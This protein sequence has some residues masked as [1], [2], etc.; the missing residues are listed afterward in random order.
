VNLLAEKRTAKVAVVPQS[1]NQEPRRP[2]LVRITA[3]LTVSGVA[4]QVCMLHENLAPNFETRLII[5]SLAE[6][7]SDMS[8]LLSSEQNV[9]RLPQMSREVSARTD[10]LA[11]WKILKFLRRERPEIVH[12]HTAKAGALGRS[13]AWLAG[14]PII[15]HTYHGHVF[16]SYFGALKNW[17]F[18]TIERILGRLSTRVI[19]VSES[20]Q[21]DLCSKYRVAPRE[22]FVVIENGFKLE[23]FSSL[24]RE[25]ARR[26][27]GLSP[28]D[29]VVVWAGRMVPV[30]DTQ[31]LAQ[32]I[33]RAA[34]K[35][36]KICFLILGDGTQRQEFESLIR[37][38][39]NVRLFGWQHNMAPI[40]SAADLALL[41]SRNEG[42][43]TVLIEALAAGRPFVSTNVGG[44]RD[45]AVGDLQELPGNM[46][47]RVANGYLASRTPESLL[48][49]IE[50]MANN[51]RIAKEMGSVGQSFALQHFCEGRLL[52]QM[53]KLY[54]T[55]LMERPGNGYAAVKKS[56][57]SVSQN[58]DIA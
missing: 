40:W 29:F 11:F 36:S 41:T 18:L 16:H 7:E 24:C 56:S 10:F 3:R 38:Y 48:Y 4:Q 51:P 17:I 45:L 57:K 33:R 32:V 12:T 35:Q 30:K 14:V 26:Q 53:S 9:L 2:K 58:E 31:L 49:C 23:R 55:L 37:G 43:P 47:H 25:D 28:D 54:Q 20:Q 34:E 8:H 39:E 19:A 1:E 13:A 42:T 22:K 15:V 21:H 27:L 6:G 44:V 46:G 5:G 52:E 50:Q